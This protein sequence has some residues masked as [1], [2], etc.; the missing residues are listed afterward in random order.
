[1]RDWVRRLNWV[2]VV[3]AAGGLSACV[4]PLA[5]SDFA[6]PLGA[7][8]IDVDP[9]PL[10]N[11]AAQA[12][13]GQGAEAAVYAWIDRTA[14]LL[15]LIGQSP[16][17]FAFGYR[18]TARFGWDIDGWLLI[19]EP[20]GDGRNLF[21]FEPG[22]REPY[23]VRDIQ[24]GHGFDRGR[25]T[26]TY[27]PE[28]TVLPASEM[29]RWR[30]HADALRRHA[31]A[32]FDAARSEQRAQSG[33]YDDAWFDWTPS[34]FEIWFEWEETRR[35][36]RRWRDYRR[37]REVRRDPA[38]EEQRRR[39]RETAEAFR[40]WRDGGFQGA[41]PPGI[42]RRRWDHNGDGIPDRRRRDRN[43]DGSPDRPR[44]GAA[45]P[46]R[47]R[48]RHGQSDVP[49]ERPRDRGGQPNRPRDV[50]GDDR[51]DRPR[52]RE[53]RPDHT[54]DRPSRG[55]RPTSPTTPDAQAEQPRQ[56]RPEQALPPVDAPVS[57]QRD[58]PQDFR[59]DERRPSRRI[60]RRVEPDF[61]PAPTAE[62][63]SLPPEPAIQSP[64]RAPEPVMQSP[65]PPPP[66]PVHQS[67]PPPPPPPLPP[68]PPEPVVESPPPPPAPPPSRREP[69]AVGEDPNAVSVA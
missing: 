66:E 68:P 9:R 54:P 16:P 32:L 48:D 17:D 45:R 59:G 41:P 18:G 31:I 42:D 69:D 40:R 5:E 50:E 3:C 46:D 64:P 13:A 19:E 37:D 29:G 49:R 55:D 35:S 23:F 25:W 6:D 8:P 11:P 61:V 53:G 28:G 12:L 14:D 24:A 44:D 20:A 33:G 7:P 63:S 38:R 56:R 58:P 10:L 21:L 2:G 34:L 62:P 39:R 1:M 26:V 27:M 43:G 65:P 57:V 30:S 15:E 36:D 67:A 52:D 51:P 22:S 47:P 4:M 60:E